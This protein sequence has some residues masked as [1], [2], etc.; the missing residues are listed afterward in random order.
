MKLIHHHF[1]I[2]DS[3]NT[4]AKR[5]ADTLPQDAITLITADE[6]TA[7]RGRFNRRWES[8]PA[9]NLLATFCFFIDPRRNDRGNIPQILAISAA[10]ALEDLGFSP[11]LKWPND[12]LI[13]SK[14]VAGILAETTMVSDQLCFVAGIGVN[15]NMPLE[16]LEKIDRPATS[17]LVEGGRG[18]EIKEVLKA[19]QTHFVKDLDLFLQKGFAPFLEEYRRRL[20]TDPNKRIRFD[21]NEKV[22]EGTFQAVNPD[23][24][25]SLKLPSGELK[26]FIVG[27]IMWPL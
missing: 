18:R 6:Q 5:H 1:N 4:W 13:S 23:G 19:L 8:P 26:T 27:E 16:A 12:I 14:K 3:T 10:K 9:K 2:I 15:V 25:L 7:G 17:L 20:S 22:W 24:S 21:D 11:I